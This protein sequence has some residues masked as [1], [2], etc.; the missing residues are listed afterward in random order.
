MHLCLCRELPKGKKYIVYYFWRSFIINNAIAG[1]PNYSSS[2][3]YIFF[4]TNNDFHEF[5]KELVLIII[6]ASLEAG[7]L[8]YT[9]NSRRI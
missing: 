8:L 9:S 3:S 2:N 4:S 6:Q 7:F 5:T 1:I